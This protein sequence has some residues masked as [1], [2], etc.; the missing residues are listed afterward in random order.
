MSDVCLTMDTKIGKNSLIERGCIINH[1]CIGNYT[2]VHMNSRL[3]YV[4]IG[5]YC[6]IA[7]DVLI[8]LGEHPIDNFSTSSF[9]YESNKIILDDGFCRFSPITVGHDVWIGAGVIVLNGVKIGNGVIVAAGAVVTKD[10]PD[11]AIVAGVP[12]KII[13]Y[14]NMDRYENM[15][16]CQWWNLDYDEVLDLYNQNIQLIVE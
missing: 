4:T 9:F 1:C 14:R 3:E 6:S 10:I 5:N 11:Y 12:A 7:H 15:I 2:M 16:N 8:G 13:K